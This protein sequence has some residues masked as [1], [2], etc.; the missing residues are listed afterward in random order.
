MKGNKQDR[1]AFTS[2][3]DAPMTSFHWNLQQKSKMAKLVSDKQSYQK[4]Q[5]K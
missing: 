3:S 2:P 4:I 1:E 5:I